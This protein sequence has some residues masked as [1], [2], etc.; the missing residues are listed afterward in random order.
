MQKLFGAFEKRAPGLEELESGPLD[1]VECINHEAT[2]P[3]KMHVFDLQ[4]WLVTE[5]LELSVCDYEKESAIFYRTF[6]SLYSPF[7]STA[8]PYNN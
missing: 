5:E 4:V 2:A 3:P 6:I 8:D 7:V 1:L